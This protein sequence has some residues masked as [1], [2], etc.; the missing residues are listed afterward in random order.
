MLPISD[1]NYKNKIVKNE[2]IDLIGKVKLKILVF[3]AVILTLLFGAQI[4]FAGNLSSDGKK[5]HEINT[6][7]HKLESENLNLKSKIAQIS[8]LTNLSQ[9]ASTLGFSKPSKIL[10]P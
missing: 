6:E 7:A 9:K 5:L 1:F 4:V 10:N 3:F 8:S 2:K